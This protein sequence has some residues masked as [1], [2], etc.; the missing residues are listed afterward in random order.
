MR[1]QRTEPGDPDADGR[2]A[3]V[4]SEAPPFDV[5]A[6]IVVR[7]TGQATRQSLLAD[8]PDVATDGRGRIIVDDEQRTSRPGIWAGGDCVNGGKEVVNAVAEGMAA[9][10][11]IDEELR[12]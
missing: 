12:R 11:S 5:H 4:T 10:R 6:D 8:L 2:P 3:V 7:A 9:A 1:C